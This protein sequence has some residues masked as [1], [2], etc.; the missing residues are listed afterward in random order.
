MPDIYELVT[1]LLGK[2]EDDPVFVQALI[3]AL[4]TPR[5][6]RKE[7]LAEVIFPGTGVVLLSRHGVF[8]LVRISDKFDGEL[9][10]TIHVGDKRSD[11]GHKLHQHP[12]PWSENIYIW[13]PFELTFEF[14]ADDRVS[15][16]II[17][18]QDSR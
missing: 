9:V 17:R 15:G 11:V 3:A 5:I 12:A 4:G 13:P 6:N 7:Q 1:N 16:V 10:G 8:E 2:S 14:D 18:R